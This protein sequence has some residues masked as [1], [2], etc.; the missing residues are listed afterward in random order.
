M[1]AGSVWVRTV[2]SIRSEFGSVPAAVLVPF[3]RLPA[4]MTGKHKGGLPPGSPS[5]SDE[6]AKRDVGPSDTVIIG[7]LWPGLDCD[8]SGRYCGN[9]ASVF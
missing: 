2:R 6:T 5:R 4:K 9:H 1:N 3:T 7:V 8:Q